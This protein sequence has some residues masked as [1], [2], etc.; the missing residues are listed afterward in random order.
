M[1]EEE[2]RRTILE[3]D[4]KHTPIEVFD[5]AQDGRVLAE[6]DAALMIPYRADQAAT[7][8]NL[9]CFHTE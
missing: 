6:P 5:F 1:R 8:F 4:Q 2:G 7:F 9:Y 3:L